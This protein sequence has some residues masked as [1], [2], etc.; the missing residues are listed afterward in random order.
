MRIVRASPWKKRGCV[1]ERFIARQATLKDNLTLLGYALRFRA[2]DSG[3]APPSG[4]SA[5][6][7]V[8]T[9]TMAF[10][11]ESLTANALAFVSLGERELL[12]GVALVLPRSKA[13]IEIADSVPCT[14]EVIL[15]CQSL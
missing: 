13:G 7:L 4:S 14:A 15:A 2:D 9:S 3:A 12:S 11:W 10:H 1:F 6:H 8:D 5:A